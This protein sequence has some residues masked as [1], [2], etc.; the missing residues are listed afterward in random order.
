MAMN[1]NAGQIGGLVSENT[2]LVNDGQYEMHDRGLY[3]SSSAQ[4]HY[5]TGYLWRREWTVT[6]GREEQRVNVEESKPPVTL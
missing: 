1:S 3:L 5:M 4:N 6:G 2:A